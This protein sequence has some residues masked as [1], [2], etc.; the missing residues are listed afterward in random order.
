M[1]KAILLVFIFLLVVGLAGVHAQ[2]DVDPSGTTITYWHQYNSGAQLD[3]I[4]ALV[5]QFNETNEWGITVEATP[6]GNYND[7]RELINNGII[8]GDLPNLV[9]GFVSDAQSY[10]LEPG[11]VVDLEPYFTDATHGFSEDDLADLNLDILNSYLIDG[12]RIGYPNQVS[13]NVMAL[14]LDMVEALGVEPPTTVDRFRTLACAAAN[15]DLTGAGGAEVRGY[16][17]KLDSS[18]AESWIAGFGGQIFHDGAWDFS[19]EEVI[20]YFQLM[21]DLY[22]EGCAYIPDTPFGNTDDFAF[23]LNPFGLGSTAGIPFILG[24]IEESGSGVDNWTLTTTP[25]LNEGD[26]PVVQLFVPGIIVLN[27]TPEQ[28]LAAWLF[29]KFLATTESQ[30]TWSTATGYFPL[31]FSA[32]DAMADFLAS[33]PHFAAANELINGGE[34]AIYVSPQ[35]L[36]YNAVRSLVATALADVTSGGMNVEEV[37]A[38]LTEEANQ[39]L[40]D[41]M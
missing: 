13:A 7:L 14:N 16:P 12:Q 10:A 33:N 3:T 8:S 26:T 4:N 17:I 19:S 27:G 35:Q 18:E 29:I 15:S 5:A 34:T 39:A 32:I 1:R 38:R 6:Q 41:S 23:G 2:T 30:V 40:E 24:N 25:V 37:A 22:N 31:R 9:A 28:N 36:S 11:V 21:Q 20:T